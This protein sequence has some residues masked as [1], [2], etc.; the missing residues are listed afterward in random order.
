MDVLQAF[1]RHGDELA[2]VVGGARRLSV[3]LH[4][5]WPKHVG[6]TVTHAV[7]GFFQL[8]VGGYGQAVGKVFVGLHAVHAPRFAILRA[9]RL[10]YKVRQQTSLY[11]FTV[12]RVCLNVG[13]PTLESSTH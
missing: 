8:F 11:L 1:G 2:L 13:L 4:H 12:V 9:L 7:D 5:T 3:P 10:L 6:F